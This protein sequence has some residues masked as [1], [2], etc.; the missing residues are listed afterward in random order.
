MAKNKINYQD[1]LILSLKRENSLL[2]SIKLPVLVCKTNEDTIGKFLK[3]LNEPGQMITD[4]SKSSNDETTPRD[5]TKPEWRTF[6][7]KDGDKEVACADENGVLVFRDAIFEAPFD[8]KEDWRKCTNVYEN[9]TLKKLLEEWYEKNAPQVLKD[10][11]TVDLLDDYE[12]FDPDQMS[13]EYRVGKQLAMFKD[14][15]NRIKGLVGERYSTWWWTKTAIRGSVG[16]AI[17]VYT[18]GYRNYGT[19]NDSYGVVPCLRPKHQE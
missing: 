10:N 15:H 2:R 7:F 13:E 11:Y 3:N 17:G 9:C 6:H 8:D 4:Q 19:A 16:F 12:I 18:S 1:E 5:F 14:W